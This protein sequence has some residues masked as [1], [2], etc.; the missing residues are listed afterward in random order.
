MSNIAL[1]V[2]ASGGIGSAVAELLSTVGYTVY[3]TYTRHKRDGL[4]YMDVTS[5]QDVVSIVDKLHN[6][7]VV[8]N[9][10]GLL[11]QKPYDMITTD[12]WDLMLDVNLLGTFLV[13]QAVLPRMIQQ[14][15]G[16]IVNIASIGGQTGG[17]LAVHYA[18]AKAGVI[19]LT[20]S[21][22][23]IGAPYVRVNCVSP[24][25]I[26]TEM[27]K[28]EISSDSGK[29]KIASIPLQRVGSVEDVARAVL[30]CISDAYVTGQVINVNG[31]ALI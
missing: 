27:T 7:Q 17:T 4:L 5:V 31:G 18:A 8:V 14:A 26:R 21:F 20:R 2:G 6:L 3:G 22:A 9:C 28:A 24:G 30:F 19:S 15:S 25:L 10:A 1:V 13:C 23:H 16:C 12:D 11:Q 29:E